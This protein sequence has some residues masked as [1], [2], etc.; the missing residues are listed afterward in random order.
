MVI[1][2]RNDN[3]SEVGGDKEEK[4]TDRTETFRG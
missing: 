4:G 2:L 3:K 1:K